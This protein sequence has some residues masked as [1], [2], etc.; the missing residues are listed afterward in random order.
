MNQLKDEGILDQGGGGGEKWWVSR[1][2]EPKGFAEELDKKRA[3]E[4]G[5]RNDSRVWGP[6]NWKN[7][8]VIY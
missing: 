6:N 3:R 4:R 7:G 1:H 2:V 5:I 8:G